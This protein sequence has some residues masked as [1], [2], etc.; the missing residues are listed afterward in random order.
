MLKAMVAAILDHCEIDQSDWQ[1]FAE[2]VRVSITGVKDP[3][4]QLLYL[5]VHPLFSKSVERELKESLDCFK[6]HGLF[7]KDLPFNKGLPGKLKSE[8]KPAEFKLSEIDL[9]R[10]KYIRKIKS[11]KKDHGLSN[12]EIIKR[13]GINR[14]F[15]SKILNNKIDSISLEYLEE[16]AR[17]I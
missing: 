14:V 2:W 17:R 7:A 3:N 8:S 16:H 5:G 11:L 1:P 4:P 13:T 10:F 12:E 15:L 9:L 6:R